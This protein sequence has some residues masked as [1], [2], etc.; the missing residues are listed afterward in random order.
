ML[1]KYSDVGQK[2]LN[3]QRGNKMIIAVDFDGTIVEH[4]FPE[5]GKEIH[6]ALS[7]LQLFQGL[8]HKVILWTCRN[9][10]YL[11]EAVQFLNNKNFYPDAVNENIDKTL[12]FGIPKIVADIYVD[13]K[14][15]PAFKPEMWLELRDYVINETW[16]IKENECK[17]SNK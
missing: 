14:G 17:K 2:L 8:G 12:D 13:D 15:F 1:G 7:T 4:K 9:K 10:E 5:I 11:K 16:E 6:N 3:G